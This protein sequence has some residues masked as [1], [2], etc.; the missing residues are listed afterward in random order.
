M[1]FLREGY[2][3]GGDSYADLLE[4]ITSVTGRMQTLPRWTQ[5]GAILGLE[6]GTEDVSSKVRAI[7]DANV[8]VAGVW[9]QDW[10][11]I[12][13]AF[14]GDRCALHLCCLCSPNR[15]G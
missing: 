9:L 4:S 2:V 1:F 6:G 12:R 10:V 11:G 8:S 3:I 15:R 5:R 13:S 14:D 7:R